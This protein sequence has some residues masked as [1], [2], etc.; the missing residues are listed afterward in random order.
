MNL[1][2][3]TYILTILDF[4]H[5]D[6]HSAC[7]YWLVTDV[8][9]YLMEYGRRRIIVRVT[10]LEDVASS[11]NHSVGLIQNCHGTRG[12]WNLTKEKV[13]YVIQSTHASN[14]LT[15]VRFAILQLFVSRH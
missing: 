9:E 11:K 2:P 3:D 4:I 7:R 10:R 5:L 8:M 15:E 14:E 1:C 6:R 12:N 13:S